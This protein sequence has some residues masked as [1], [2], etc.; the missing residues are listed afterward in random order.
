MKTTNRAR[1]EA[2]FTL[3]EIIIAILL[4]AGSLVILLGLQ[5][6][7]MGRAVRDGHKLQAMLLARQILAAVETSKDP[8]GE[9]N[10]SGP[11]IKALEDYVPNFRSLGQDLNSYETFQINLQIHDWELPIEDVKLPVKIKRADI[12]VSWSAL[13]QDSVWVTYFVPEEPLEE[14]DPDEESDDDE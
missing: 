1:P 5:S 8:L 3:I 10:Y 7:A 9:E 13:P 4:L 11:A 12:A 14:Q 6:S 2:G